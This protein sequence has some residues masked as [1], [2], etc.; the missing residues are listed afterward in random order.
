MRFLFVRN[1][2]VNCQVGHVQ[3][4]RRERHGVGGEYP[5]RQ[6]CQSKV[7]R[8]QCY[9]EKFTLDMDVSML[10]TRQKSTISKS[11]FF[12]WALV[13]NSVAFLLW[14]KKV[15]F[16]QTKLKFILKAHSQ[17]TSYNT[18]SNS[19]FSEVFKELDYTSCILTL[20]RI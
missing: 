6:Y 17:K 3:P 12:V 13:F 16:K 4:Y 20:S 2:K 9:Q 14:S 15:Y 5:T 8:N 18:L 11:K 19:Q 1:D 10:A 7:R